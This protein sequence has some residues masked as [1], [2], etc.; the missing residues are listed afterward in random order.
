[1]LIS[2]TRCGFALANTSNGHFTPLLSFSEE[3]ALFTT[4]GELSFTI[5]SEI[6]NAETGNNGTVSGGFSKQLNPSIKPGSS[7]AAGPRV[8][9]LNSSFSSSRLRPPPPP[10]FF[11][12]ATVVKE[13]EDEEEEEEESAPPKGW[14][15]TSPLGSPFKNIAPL[16]PVSG[17]CLLRGV[18]YF[19]L[20]N[21]ISLENDMLLT[22]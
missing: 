1:M 9:I 11:T 14:L 20:W 13:E 17:Q 12:A 22:P 10:A 5:G 18:L 21:N 2:P 4:S 16:P 15:P 7:S 6:A 8:E 19:G 3:S